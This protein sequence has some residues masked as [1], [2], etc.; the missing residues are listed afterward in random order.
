MANILLR[1]PYYEYHP[2]TGASSA[3]LVLQ[4]EGVT[5]YTIIKDTPTETV[6]FEI[7]ELAKDYLDITFAGSYQAQK[8]NISGEI[9][10]YDGVNATGSQVGLSINFTH[11]GFDGYWDYYNTSNTK[12]FC[13][14][15]GSCVMQDNT[16]MYVP[17]GTGGFIPVL[18][19]GTIVYNAFTGTTT[20]VAVGSPATTITI[21]R[22]DCS[23]YMPIK[24]TF[25]N[26]YGALQDIYFDKKHVETISTEVKKYKN[27]NL[28]TTGTY[29]KYAHQYRTLIKTGKE[30]M[31]LNTGYIDE[32]MNEAI[33][34]LM[35]SE[36]VWMKMGNEYHPIDIS[37][38]SLTLKTSVNDKL[39]NYTIEVEHA[40]DHIDRVR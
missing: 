34:Q 33:K 4:I 39:V 38:N 2:R 1:S 12:S 17:E 29:S 27:N 24:V 40:H 32:G 6:L 22:T 25:V 31:T 5:R 37:T 19:S 11:V 15:D 35:F 18:S 36:Q 14:G 20:S 8:I 7:A 3:K 26:K 21:K 9:F 28:S 16:I 13:S 10:F 23:K 30:R